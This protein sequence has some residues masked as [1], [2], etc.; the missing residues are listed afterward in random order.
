MLTG[1]L[2]DLRL[3]L[4]GL[5]TYFVE[6][7]S[8]TDIKTILGLSQHIDMSGTLTAESTKPLLT[9]LVIAT[10]NTVAPRHAAMYLWAELLGLQSRSS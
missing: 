7:E 5:S 4:K 8:A 1:D 6:K 2:R 3:V 10:E 9:S